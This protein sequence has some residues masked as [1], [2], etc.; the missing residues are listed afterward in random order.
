MNI[1]QRVI[2]ILFLFGLSGTPKK[3]SFPLLNLHNF[4]LPYP[5]HGVIS[6]MASWTKKIQLTEWRFLGIST[7]SIDYPQMIH[8]LSILS[9]DDLYINQISLGKSMGFLW[10]MASSHV[11]KM[12]PEADPIEISG[13]R[14][15]G[16]PS[17]HQTTRLFCLHLENHRKT[18]GKPI[19]KPIGKWWLSGI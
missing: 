4:T 2:F 13:P 9:I 3:L 11:K 19:G 7:I 14:L 15:P 8:R 10:S 12:T 1:Y 16:G 5:L 6:H 17:S 18:I